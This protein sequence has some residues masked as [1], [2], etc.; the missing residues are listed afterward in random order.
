MSITTQVHSSLLDGK[1]AIGASLDIA[2]AFDTVWPHL[3]LSRLRSLDMPKY[4]FQ[5]LYR[6]LQ[7]R[8][9]SFRIQGQLYEHDLTLGVPQGS[10]LS[11]TLFILFM[12]DLF[13]LP[14]INMVTAYADDIL[15]LALESIS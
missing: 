5:W 12:E 9:A 11:P 15:C 4:L 1:H 10:S 6:F 2:G 3:L 13:R 8:R 7:N 14:T